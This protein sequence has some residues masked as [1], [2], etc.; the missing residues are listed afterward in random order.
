MSDAS[1][2]EQSDVKLAAGPLAAE[3][4]SPPTTQPLTSHGSS[5]L[6]QADSPLSERRDPT[7]GTGDSPRS[8]REM[9]ETRQ[10]PPTHPF[11]DEVGPSGTI[12]FKGKRR[13]Y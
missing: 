12:R 9:R 10:D 1:N 2:E 3:G 7:Y 8:R 5:H 13:N 11:Q 4:L 6:D